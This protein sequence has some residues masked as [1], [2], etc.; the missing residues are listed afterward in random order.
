MAD[1]LGGLGGLGGGGSPEPATLTASGPVA[2]TAYSKNGLELTLQLQ[3]NLE[4][5]VQILARFRNKSAFERI[6]GV[7]LQAAVPKTQKLQLQAISATELEAG[8]EATQQMRVGG[9]KGVSFSSPFFL[10]FSGF[11]GR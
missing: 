4:G 8:E 11:F 1:L 2:H 7:G 6:S 5:L 10:Y 9:S 3:R